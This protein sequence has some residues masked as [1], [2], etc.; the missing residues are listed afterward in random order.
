MIMI[1]K[2]FQTYSINSWKLASTD[3][4]FAL[5]ISSMNYFYCSCFFFFAKQLI[6]VFLHVILVKGSMCVSFTYSVYNNNKNMMVNCYRNDGC[7]FKLLL[8]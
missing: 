5:N 4:G 1:P 8:L 6:S 2:K 3:F 7:L